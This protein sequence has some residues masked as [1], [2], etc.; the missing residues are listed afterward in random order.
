VVWMVCGEA[1][2]ADDVWACGRV[3]VA[4][5]DEPHVRQRAIQHALLQRDELVAAVLRVVVALERWRR[6]A[7][8]DHGS[9]RSRAHHSDVTTVIPRALFLLV[10]AVMLLV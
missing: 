6:R 3:F 8:H 9:P 4:H 2:R 10:G 5:V 7:E 1:R